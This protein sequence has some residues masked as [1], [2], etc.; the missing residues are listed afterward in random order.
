MPSALLQSNG[1]CL[2]D[3]GDIWAQSCWEKYSILMVWND[4][5]GLHM[6]I[7]YG[8]NFLQGESMWKKKKKMEGTYKNDINFL[9]QKKDFWRAKS[10]KK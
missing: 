1:E 8:W 3:K 2:N 7:S 6:E 5:S 9:Q 10:I 4:G